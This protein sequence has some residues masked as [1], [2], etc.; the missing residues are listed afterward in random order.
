MI[1]KVKILSKCSYCDGKAYLPEGEAV[2]TKGEVYMRFLPC[3]KCH[4][5]GLSGKWINLY[6]LKQLLGQSVCPHEHV[7]NNGGHHFSAGEVWDDIE[8]V[9]SDCGE[10]LG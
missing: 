10:A 5:S 1:N 9:C 8:E 2:D 4:G 3:P 7:S 6:E